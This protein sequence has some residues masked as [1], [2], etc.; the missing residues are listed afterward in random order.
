MVS[1]LDLVSV[2]KQLFAGDLETIQVGTISGAKVSQIV[3]DASILG[4]HD[5]DLGMLTRG[6][7]VSQDKISGG[8]PS[9][10]QAGLGQPDASPE[11]LTLNYD[12]DWSSYGRC[13][14][15]P[16]VELYCAFRV[17]HSD[18]PG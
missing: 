11:A 16:R 15:L 4:F 6:D 10:G 14:Y 17:S 1:D 3:L 5:P 18:T 8:A 7:I 2:L 13:E 9:N 12:K